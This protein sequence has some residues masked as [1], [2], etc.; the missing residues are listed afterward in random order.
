MPR[1]QR[2]ARDGRGSV[3]RV[4]RD[5]EVSAGPASF[6][7]AS[8]PRHPDQLQANE[9]ANTNM[10]LRRVV[11]SATASV[12]TS[13]IFLVVHASAALADGHDKKKPEVPVPDQQLTTI[14]SNW[15]LWLFG[16]LSVA[17][18]LVLTLAGWLYTTA[19]GNP[20]QVE[21]AKTAFKSAVV[22]Y[23]IAAVAPILVSI[24]TRLMS[25]PTPA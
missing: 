21:K 2:G 1:H 9:G 19:G 5:E 24:L 13:W 10:R 3:R 23:G 12:L 8:P 11:R 18:T 6:P 15:R 25:A 14:A 17:A 4:V 20:T 22:G 16:F 7:R